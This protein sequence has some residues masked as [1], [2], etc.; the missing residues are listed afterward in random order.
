SVFGFALEGVHS[1][2]YIFL[3]LA[4]LAIFV[5]HRLVHSRLGRAWFYVRYD[6]DAAEAMGINRV[7][8][9]LAAY[10]IGAIFG[11]IGGVFFA[12][13]LGSISPPAFSFEQSV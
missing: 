12:A 3:A 2:Y 13:N 7:R 5:S 1:F 11:S 4:I 9:K 8:V 10:V 6:E